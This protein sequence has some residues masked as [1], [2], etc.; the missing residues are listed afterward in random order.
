MRGVPGRQ[1]RLLEIIDRVYDGEDCDRMLNSL[2]AGLR[3]LVAFS[4]GVLLPIDPTTLELQEAFCFDCPPENNSPYLRHYAAF[5]PFVRRHPGAIVVNQSARLSDVVGSRDL[6]HS[7]FADFLPKVPYRH[8]LAAVVG[9]DGQPLAALSVHRRKDQRDFRSDEAAVID[10]IA[11]HLGRALALRRWQAD[12][13]AMAMAGLVVFDAGGQLLFMNAVAQCLL[14]AG[15]APTVLAALPPGGPGKLRLGLQRYRVSRLP[16]RAASLLTRFA[17]KSSDACLAKANGKA[18]AVAGH[19]ATVQSQGARLTIVCLIPFQH[20]DDVR[21][22]LG[23]HRLSPR[24]LEITAQSAL[25]GLSNAQ[26]AR[27]LCI[28][29]DTVKSHLREAYRKIGVGSRTELLARLLS[30]DNELPPASPER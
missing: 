21:R 1:E 6:D 29:E 15:D 28:S 5:D 9:F 17:V 30:L 13:A 10:R 8:A 18:D 14:P 25:S 12:P 3:E 26:L 24:E 27:R 4:S 22:R 23:Y 19:W 20:R 7:E 16:W 11:P 2:F